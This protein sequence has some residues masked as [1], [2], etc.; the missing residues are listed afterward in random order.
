MIY[1][2]VAIRDHFASHGVHLQRVYEPS[3]ACNLVSFI[4]VVKI[5]TFLLSFSCIFLKVKW[6]D[7]LH[8]EKKSFCAGTFY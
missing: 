2:Q 6:V 5:I 3:N 7:Q 1:E 8:R 4:Y